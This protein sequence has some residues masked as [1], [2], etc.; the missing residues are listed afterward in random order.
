MRQLLLGSVILI[1]FA[2]AI[3]LF[4]ISCQKESNAQTT[5]Y[6]LPPATTTTLGGVIVGNGLA[7]TN[8]GTLSVTCC[9]SGSMQ[10][11]KILFVKS[12]LSGP[13]EWSEIWT[14]NFDGTNPQK[15]NI[16]VPAGMTIDGE[17]G[18]TISPDRQTIFFSMSNTTTNVN[19]IYSCKLDGTNLIKIIDGT[20]TSEVNIGSAY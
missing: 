4:Q 7:V 3:T 15:I 20:G 18:P 12:F 13:T 19:H 10:Q 11:N 16:T 14:A 2:I 9:G 1:I 8:N 17:L 5:T 6:T